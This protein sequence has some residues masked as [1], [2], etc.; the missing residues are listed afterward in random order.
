MV[1]ELPLS[2]FGLLA[3]TFGCLACGGVCDLGYVAWVCVWLVGFYAACG[4]C[5]V[6][7]SISF[8]VAACEFPCTVGWHNISLQV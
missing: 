6:R 8:D 5:M 7:M 2:G 1:L 4:G 3:C